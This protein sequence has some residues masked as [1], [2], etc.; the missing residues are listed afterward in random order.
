[1][2][3]L[4]RGGGDVECDYSSQSHPKLKF[5]LFWMALRIEGWDLPYGTGAFPSV[6][7]KGMDSEISDCSTCNHIFTA[8][9]ANVIVHRLL[10]TTDV[11]TKRQQSPVSP[12]LKI[13][14]V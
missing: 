3:H 7:G 9:Q 2:L 14:N 1:M 11:H 5:W 12:N 8:T 13:L 6:L 4:G 10:L